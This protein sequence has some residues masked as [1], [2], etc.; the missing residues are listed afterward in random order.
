MRVIFMGT[1]DFAIPALDSLA[2]G[3][4]EVVAVY[5][6]PDRPAGRGR[7]P[8]G[9]PV[10]KAAL[11]YG[12]T[13]RQPL[14]LG[15]PEEK[16]SLA[17]LRPD[18]IVLAAFGLLLPQGILDIPPFGCLNVHPSLLPKHRGASPVA[19]AILAGDE[20]TGVSIMR[21][22]KGMDTGPILAQ[23]QV[24]VLPQDTTGSLTARLAQTGAQLLMATLPPWLAGE[25]TPQPQDNEKATY[26][27]RIGKESGRIDWHCPAVE[28]WRRVRA[29]QPWPGCYT[30]WQGKTVKVVG[31]IPLP[32]EG[33]PGRVVAIERGKPAS[34]GVQ[35]GEGVLGLLQLQ[36]EGKRVMAAEEFVRGQ[37]SFIGALL[38]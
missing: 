8:I 36:L 10:K 17:D 25:I 31:A 12:L 7:G 18:V 13:V 1:P 38:P 11:K 22:D 23:Q 20:I 3:E 21:M 24:P 28:L 35:T 27:E 5:T 16:K 2:L 29:F 6:Q 30:A 37:R 26:S 33:E 32:G 15:Q 9:P 14:S 4:Y 19:A 34:I